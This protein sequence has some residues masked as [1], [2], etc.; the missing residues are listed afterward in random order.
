MAATVTQAPN[1]VEQLAPMLTATR[2]TLHAAGIPEPVQA[3]V[4][5]AG[6]WRAANVDGSIPDAPD[7]FIAVAKH[8]RR[9]RPRKDPVNGLA[10]LTPGS[11]GALLHRGPLRSV[12]ATGR[13]AYGSSKPWG[14]S[15]VEKCWVLAPVSRRW[16]CRSTHRRVPAELMPAGRDMVAPTRRPGP[17]RLLEGG[18][19]WSAGPVIHCQALVNGPSWTTRRRR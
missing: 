19:G 3:L 15:G 13:A 7:L 12:R 18:D 17:A 9:G 5:D 10:T 11:S 6:Y 8:G 14:A 4:A 2:D 16:R 1:D